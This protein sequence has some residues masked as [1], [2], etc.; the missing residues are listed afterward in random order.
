MLF[1]DIAISKSSALCERVTH[2]VLY[3]LESEAAPLAGHGCILVSLVQL[4]VLY[5]VTQAELI[6]TGAS[7]HVATHFNNGQ[8]VDQLLGICS[9]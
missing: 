3:F 8:L 6:D 1:C 5:G 4:N 2:S 7:G 9:V